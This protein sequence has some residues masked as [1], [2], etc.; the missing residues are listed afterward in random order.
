MDCEREF[1]M[2]SID[3]RWVLFETPYHGIVLCVKCERIFSEA[4]PHNY[5]SSVKAPWLDK[6]SGGL[7]RV[8]FSRSPWRS[9]TM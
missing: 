6:L 2:Y 9:G 7:W 5:S 8:L 3:T 4:D 1:V